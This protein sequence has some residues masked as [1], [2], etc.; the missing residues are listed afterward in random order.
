MFPKGLVFAALFFEQMNGHFGS[1]PW[2]VFEQLNVWFCLYLSGV[3]HQLYSVE[4]DLQ[5]HEATLKLTWI[6]LGLNFSLLLFLL[7]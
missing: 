5:S 3:L 4:N 2:M 7:Y 6:L 1:L